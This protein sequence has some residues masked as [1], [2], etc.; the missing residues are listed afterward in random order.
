MI[1]CNNKCVH[2]V[3]K[4]RSAPGEKVRL[5]KT[6]HTLRTGLLTFAHGDNQGL[7]RKILSSGL[8]NK[9]FNFNDAV[10][11]GSKLGV[12]MLNARHRE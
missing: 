4:C 8:T 1:L 9:N 7:V 6:F 11:T 2:T 12:C 3:T 10:K 5:I